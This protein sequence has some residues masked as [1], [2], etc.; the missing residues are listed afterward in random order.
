MLFA[1]EQNGL[2]QD[3]CNICWQP[4][5]QQFKIE[6]E[7]RASFSSRIPSFQ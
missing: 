7:D 1:L 4:I 6:I 2:S 3:K 5:I